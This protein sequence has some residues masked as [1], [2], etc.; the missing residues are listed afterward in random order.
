MRE[1][2]TEAFYRPIFNALAWLYENVAFE[3]LGIAIIL[4]T[5]AVRVLLFPLFHKTTKHQ[6]LTQNLQPEIQRIQK[7]HKD[8]KETQAQKI[9]ELYSQHK[10][11]PLTP[12]IALII[13]LPI[14]IVLYRVFIHGFS[15]DALNLLY[16]SIDLPDVPDQTF[17][18]LIDLTQSNTWIAGFA[19]LAQY[20]QGRLSLAKINKNKGG[21]MSK[22]EKVGKNMV[23]FMPFL[24]LAI[25]FSL[26]A[27]VG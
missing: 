13:Q 5:L 7:K 14:I 8:N 24:T 20:V 15:G 23:I 21:E 1:F 22:A 10:I 18:G 25:L 26:P 11:N 3:D 9:M 4:L 6:R 17:L 16:P 27:A 2:F 19:A 12:L